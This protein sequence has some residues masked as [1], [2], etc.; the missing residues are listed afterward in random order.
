MMDQVLK[1]CMLKVAEM[2]QDEGVEEGMKGE[3]GEEELRQIGA[4]LYKV[5][6]FGAEKMVNM[7]ELNPNGEFGIVLLVLG[8]WWGGREEGGGKGRWAESREAHFC[9][10]F[11]FRSSFCFADTDKLVCIKG[12]VIR[13]TPVIPDMKTGEQPNPPSSSYVS[14]A[15]TS[16]ETHLP[17]L[18]FRSRFAS[19]LPVP[20]L[21]PY[22]PG[23]H[24]TRQ[25]R[26]TRR[27]SSRSL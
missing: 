6:P 7:R 16:N 14:D 19:L 8:G 4:N 9:S 1:D 25:D 5:R 2:D 12:L 23:R 21:L 17:F 24:R 15:S 27:L 26:R 22:P 18:A 11:R 13:A 10:F 20:R 3:M